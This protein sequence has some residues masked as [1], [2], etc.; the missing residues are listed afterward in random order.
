MFGCCLFGALFF[1]EG[2][3]RRSRSG[4]KVRGGDLGGV[5]WRGGGK[6][7]LRMYCVRGESIF[8]Q[9]NRFFFL[10]KSIR[11][12]SNLSWL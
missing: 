7:V 5:E 6:S 2:R 12:S 9:E 10:K 4:E 3:W 8:K 11:K 1:P